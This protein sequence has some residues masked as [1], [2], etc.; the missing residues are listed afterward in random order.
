[1]PHHWGQTVIY[2]NMLTA[3]GGYSTSSVE[4]LTSRNSNWEWKKSIPEVGVPDLYYFS[5]LVIKDS[6]YVFGGRGQGGKVW[7]YE[8][9][10]EYQQLRN[11]KRIL[12]NDNSQWTKQTPL[13]NRMISDK[14]HHHSIQHSDNQISHYYAGKGD[15]QR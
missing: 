6:L 2:K 8:E 3:I 9:L 13:R 14:Y 12:K 15:R 5:A 4:V 11:G 1:M 7:K 10:K